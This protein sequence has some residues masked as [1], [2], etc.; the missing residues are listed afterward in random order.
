MS[1]GTTYSPTIPVGGATSY[2]LWLVLTYSNGYWEVY[3]GFQEDF[4]VGGR[5][6]E[7][8]DM[9]GELSVEEFVMGEENFHEGSA[10]FTSITYKKKQWKN[11]Y[12]KVFL[13]AG[14]KKQH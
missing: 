1:F 10:G 2:K 5:G 3:R 4:L 6:W 9:L 8:G 11:K 12:E 7:E 13:S 14:S